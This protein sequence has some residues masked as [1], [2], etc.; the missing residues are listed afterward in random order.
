MRGS[1]RGNLLPAGSKVGTFPLHS[2]DTFGHTLPQLCQFIPAFTIS[3]LSTRP[4]HLSSFCLTRYQRQRRLHQSCPAQ[5]LLRPFI[6]SG[7]RYRPGISFLWLISL[8][9]VGFTPSKKRSRSSTLLE[10]PM[11]QTISERCSAQGL[12]ATAGF[13]DYVVPAA[14]GH[15]VTV[16]STLHKTQRGSL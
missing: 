5:I 11:A 10:S 1:C 8:L 6:S 2:S 15:E 3:C 14:K 12:M 16:M 13:S 9:M 4:F 7:S